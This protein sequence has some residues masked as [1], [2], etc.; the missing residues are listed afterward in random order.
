MIVSHHARIVILMG[1]AGS[2]KTTI[3]QLLAKDLNWGFYDGDDFHPKANVDK[4]SQGIAL[5][6]E[7]RDAWLAALDGVIR[8]LISEAQSAVIACS[9]LKQRYRDR[10]A[11]DRTEVVFAYL[12]G[13]YDLTHE[14][15]VSRKVHFMKADLLDSQFDTLEEPEGVLSIDIAQEP[16]IILDQI[17][18]ALGLA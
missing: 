1:V 13:G 14:R 12:K 4:M 6:D 16:A 2:G 17:K 3:G 5:S 7:D 15:L 11:A 18:Q 8:H 10:L 9:A